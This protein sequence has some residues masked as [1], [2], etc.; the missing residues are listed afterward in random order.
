MLKLIKNAHL[1]APQHL[2][3]NDILIAEEKIALI[4]R[5][6]N[7]AGLP[8]EV[9]NA[10]GMIVTPGFIDQHVH[11]IG[12]GGQ[13]G[14]ASMVPEVTMSELVSCGT[15]C[16]VGLL[17][18][19]GF[20]KELTALYSKTKAIDADGLSAYMLTGFYGLPSKTLMNSVADDLIFIDKV[21]GCKLALSDDR[22]AFPTELEILRLLHQV[23]LGG[24]TSGKRGVLHIHVGALSQGITTLLDIVRS[25]P[26]FTQYISPTHLIRTEELFHQAIEFAS[27]GGMIDFTTGGTK[28]D[29]PH[30]CV[31]KALESRVSIEQIT[32]SSDG[33]GGLRKVDKETGV[34]TYSS[35]P[36]N[37]NFHEMIMLVKEGQ[38]PLEKALL[39]ITQNP[40]RNLNLAHKGRISVGCDADFCF[41][42]NSLNLTDVI[43]RGQIVMKDKQI[44]KKGTYEL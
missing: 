32:F 3:M 23:R 37:L 6:I 27:L 21:I 18:T 25:Y 11:V 35:I 31:L 8:V 33:H 34:M 10:H 26:T 7:I 40:A 41:L 4:D 39:L 16:V 15:T 30:R 43:A 28:F 2:G 22:S 24:F 44:I 17:G 19:D 42:D 38:I 1:Y 13:A 36:L 29:V 5:E 20:V 12:G 9:I 14:Y